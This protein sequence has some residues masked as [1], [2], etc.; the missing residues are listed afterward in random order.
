M[1]G[2]ARQLLAPIFKQPVITFK[3]EGRPRAGERFTA[4]HFELA[5]IKET[6]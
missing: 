6:I 3:H 5:G 2:L 4:S 1:G